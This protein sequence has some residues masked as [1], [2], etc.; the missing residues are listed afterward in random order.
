MSN[1]SPI[2]MKQY[3]VIKKK[4]HKHPIIRGII[5]TFFILLLTLILLIIIVGGYAAYRIYDVVKD[6]RLSK[7]DLAIKYENSIVKD[8]NGNTIAVLNGDENRQS[9]TID[10]MSKYLP[11]AFVSIEDERFYEHDGIDTK[12]TLAAT[13]TY[14]TN[15]GESPFGGSTITQQLVKNLTQENEDTWQRKVREMARAYYLEQEMSKDEILELYLNLI[16]LGDTIY[17]VQQGSIYYFDKNASDLSLAESAFLAGINHSPNMY[18]AFSEDKTEI[19]KI[20]T[21]TK[22]VLDKMYE[23]GKIT[24]KEYDEAKKEVEK[25]LAFKEGNTT[26]VMFS[27]YIDAALTQII[28][29]LQQRHDW[30]Y[31]QAR[32][33]LFGGGFTIYTTL[34]PDIQQI[35]D[36]ESNDPKLYRTAIDVNGDVQ[37]SQAAIVILDHTNGHVVAISG[38]LR[39]KTTAFGFNRAT[40]AKRQTGSSMKP[41]AVVAPAIDEGVIT[42]ATVFDDD[43]TTFM[44]GNENFKPKNYNYYRGLITTREAIC[45]SQNI[46]MVKGISLLTPEKSAEFLKNAGLS[47]DEKDRGLS[48]ALGGLTYGVTPLEMAGAYGAIANNGLYIEPTFYTKVVDSEG[49]IEME[50]NQRKTQIIKPATAFVVK[51]ILTEPVKQGGTATICAMDEMSVAAKTGT[52]NSDYDRWLCGFTPYYTATVWFGYDKNATVTR[53]EY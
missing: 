24:D 34:D 31:E 47:L 37:E 3:K 50:V 43:P 5:E 16:F 14:L 44:Y 49:N 41:L 4:K 12:R 35:L 9:I 23:L 45:T 6:V 10:K 19:K 15:K 48:L 52:T 11:L 29:E 51:D 38:G 53:M 26:Q 8:K 46:P 39:E 36:D 25:G 13:F 1:N 27:Y 2:Q 22:V 30:T 42:A 40:D 20:K 17:G 32:L 33:Y 28:N 21:R 7:N 18:D